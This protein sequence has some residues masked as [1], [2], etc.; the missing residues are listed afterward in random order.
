MHR[1]VQGKQFSPRKLKGEF[2]KVYKYQFEKKKQHPHS[3]CQDL[4]LGWK[5]GH[6]QKS[7]R[8]A[9]GPM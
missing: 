6:A 7:A 4:E 2:K 1:K 5:S 3:K 8:K 9:F